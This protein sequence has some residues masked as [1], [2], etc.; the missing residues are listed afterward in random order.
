VWPKG[1]FVGRATEGGGEQLVA[2]ADPE[3][4]DAPDELADLARDA[5]KGGR[6]AWAVRE[7]DAVRP[8]GEHFVGAGGAGTTVTLAMAPRWRTIV[9][10]MPKS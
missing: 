2:E 5:R 8:E 4:R 10:L 6:V 9:V 1:S 7:E 3:D